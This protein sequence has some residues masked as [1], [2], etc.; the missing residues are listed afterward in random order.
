MPVILRACCFAAEK[1]RDQRRKDPR[2]TPYINHPLEVSMV[3][4]DAGVEDPEILAAAL[5]HDTL[6]DTETSAEELDVAFGPRVRGWVEE[7]TDDKT[8]PKHVRKRQQVEKA[9]AATHEAKLIKLA[10]KICNVRDILDH[11]PKGWSRE[12]CEDYLFWSRE[13][14]DGLRGASQVLEERFDKLYSAFFK[15]RQHT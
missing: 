3:L 1:H 13:V 6:E 4:N 12:R 8:L 7:L 10:D 5:L 9:P 11:P 15:A 2:A 14:V